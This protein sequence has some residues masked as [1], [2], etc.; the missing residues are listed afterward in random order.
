MFDKVV[1]SFS[2]KVSKYGQEMANNLQPKNIPTQN[3]KQ[4]TDSGPSSTEIEAF[5]RII[6]VISDTNWTLTDDFEF[7]FNNGLI[8]ISNLNITQGTPEDAIS[9]AIISVDIPELTAA[10]SDVVAGGERRMNVRMQELFRFSLRFRDRDALKLRRY[11][12]KI[13]MA[14]QYEYFE[15]IKSSIEIKNKGVLIFGTF[16]AMITGISSITFDN[17]TTAIAE[18]TLQMVCRTYS[19]I[20]VKTF[21]DSTNVDNFVEPEDKKSYTDSEGWGY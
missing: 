12:E 15:T 10:E 13:W 7:V 20:D 4:Q 17:N 11:F 1:S 19:D 8:P 16:D 14:Q 5:S 18:F 2:S 6:T 9:S 3:T 21:G